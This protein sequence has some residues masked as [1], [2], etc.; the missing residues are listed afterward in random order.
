MLGALETCPDLFV[1]FGG[2]RHAAGL[3]ME[4]SRIKELRSRINEHADGVLAPDDLR[5]RIHIDSSVTFRTLGS[6]VVGQV[7]E[8]AP[9]GAGNP[10]PVF[11]STGVELVD[12]PRVLKDR[13]LK[14]AF[15]QDGRVFRAIAWRSAEREPFLAQHRACLDLAFALEQNE[16]NGE[17]SLELSMLDAR[18]G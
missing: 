12:G 4:A 16:F 9:F 11:M 10:R 7:T 14:M 2:H 18:P 17:T 1:R 15:K 8:L 6:E 5:P 13:H 3:T